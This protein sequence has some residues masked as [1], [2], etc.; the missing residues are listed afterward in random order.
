ML[1][2]SVL[3]W[4]LRKLSTCRGGQQDAISDVHA[5]H[6][7]DGGYVHP[8]YAGFR[9]DWNAILDA[10]LQPYFQLYLI[11]FEGSIHKI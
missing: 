11:S 5:R 4:S 9:W 7:S 6:V 1:S 8:S 10:Y 2:L 3:G